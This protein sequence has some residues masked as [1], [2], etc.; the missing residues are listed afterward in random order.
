MDKDLGFLLSL[1][2]IILILFDYCILILYQ[3]LFGKKWS[4][5]KK[6]KKEFENHCL[7]LLI[8]QIG[9]NVQIGKGYCSSLT[10]NMCFPEVSTCH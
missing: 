1:A 10:M 6:K 5:K 4:A 7:N 8:S 9:T 3:I 2:S